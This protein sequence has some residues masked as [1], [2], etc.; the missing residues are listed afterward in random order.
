MINFNYFTGI[1]EIFILEYLFQS[2]VIFS[3]IFT[4]LFLPTYPILLILV[5][6]NKFNL[7]E[8]ISL[9]IVIN[10]AFY[11][12]LGYI[13]YWIN[14]PITGLYFYYCALI[15][16]LFLI[17]II[18]FGEWKKEL[19]SFIKPKEI[20]KNA[21]EEIYK[22][23]L[24][25]FF[26]KKMPLNAILLILF[27]FLVCI[28]NI[29][30]FS[31]FVGT[32]PWLHIL[33][34]Q[35]ITNENI[36]PTKAYHGELG[37][38]IF[39]AVIHFFSG[40]SHLLIPKF[41]VFYTFFLSA[42]IFYNI[43]LR[44]FKN[45]NLAFFSVFIL[46]FSSLGFSTMM[47]QYWPS[48]SA[49]IK[50]IAIFFL[51]YVRL[52]NFIKLERPQKKDI[53]SDIFFFYTIIT[54]IFISAV[55]THVVTSIVFL[56]SYL[57]LY[58]I[59]FLKDYKRGFDFIFLLG[60][61]GI[62]LLLSYFGIG[63]GH[64]WF[65]IPF[66]VTWYILLFMLTVGITTGTILF[67]RLQ[68]SIIF[69]KG[70]F[71]SA[72]KG[73][74]NNFY[75]K[76]E[77]NIIFPLIFSIILLLI[78]FLLIVNLFW[79]KMDVINI[80]YITEIILISAFAIWG[81]ILFQKK[82]RGKPIFIW[83]L[84][85][86]LILA[87]G[88]LFNVFILSNLI[89]QRI[90]Y[91]IPPFIVIGFISYIYKLNRLKK[92]KNFRY[93][94]IILI[95]I[96]FSL[97]TSYFYESVS[98]KVF[99]VKKRDVSS[100]QWYSNNTQNKNVIIAKYGWNHV[101]NLYD[102]LFSTQNGSFIYNRNFIFIKNETDLFPPDNHFN[103]SGIN[104]LKKLKKQYKTEVYLIF[105]GEYII[106]KGGNLFGQLSKDELEEYYNL[107]YLNKICSSKSIKGDETPLYWV[108]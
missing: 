4:I 75:K 80:F 81:I 82:P 27:I 50:C 77:D 85:L 98:Y 94:F 26:K 73:E 42:L 65:L 53:L 47:L 74:G 28:M 21:K 100:I 54:I 49:L 13:G 57:W 78:V 9:T 102:Y 45:Q 64:Y 86:I 60:L 107:D 69:A 61:L 33:N 38:S 3:T 40:L 108:I 106:N 7:L 17:F 68:K 36:I 83:G 48:G 5:K 10:S 15:F 16:F 97:F 101:F 24:Y 63:S 37:L 1:S 92:F 25:R 34:S 6:E 19:Y 90:L 55:L 46:E 104:I 43:S 52:Q 72:I 105:E 29:M 91:L 96:T 88:F 22:Y 18:I 12:F 71:S 79:L 95:I 87:I 20:L 11:I 66:N 99:E 56:I 30:K 103:E 2:C 14:I 62:F 35:I 23:S 31:Y 58:F 44:I 39:G 51:L 76:I 32:D 8:N 59:Y 84:G 89:W 67:W 93:K 70:R 41:F